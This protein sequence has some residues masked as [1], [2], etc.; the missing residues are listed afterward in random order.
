MRKAVIAAAA[1]LAAVVVFLLATLPSRPGPVSGAVGDRQAN[2]A[3]PGAYHVHSTVSDG[4][5][6]RDAIARSAARA[7][8]R[9]VIFTDHGDGTRVPQP[10]AYVHGVLCIDGVEIST[11]GGHYVALDMRPASYPLGGE[12]AAV[13]EDVRRLGGFGIAAHPSSARGEL[14][15]SDWDAPF[16]AV[17]WLNADSEWRDESALSLLRLPFDYLIRPAAALASMLDRPAAAIAR[18]DGL[19]S[20]RPVVGIAGHDAHGGIARPAEVGWRVGIPGIP[21]YEASFRAFSLRAILAAPLSGGP[22]ADARLVLDAI[23][24]G[25]VFTAI[26]AI[27]APAQLDFTATAGAIAAQMGDALPFDPAVELA[28]RSTLPEAGRLVLICDG[29][30]VAESRTGELR[31][32]PEGPMACRPEVRAPRA[33]GDPPVPWIVGNAIHLLAAVTEPVGAEP[34]F[35]TTLALD[36]LDWAVEKDP[37]SRASLTMEDGA[38]ILKYELRGGERVSQYVAAAAALAPPVPPYDRILFTAESSAP[39]RISVQLR[40]EGVERWVRSVY[41]EP[42]ARRAIVPLSALVSADGGAGAAAPDFRRAGS[43]LFVVDLTNA[44]PGAV[45]LVRISDLSFARALTR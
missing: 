1:I 3:V 19:S 10:P 33:P 29:R 34:L 43:I 44:P 4:A 13:I 37:A 14:G 40:F 45:G 25:R 15:W 9:F 36:H 35:E 31:T 41:V 5:A 26:D 38:L 7:G 12:A 42:D 8:L 22:A 24:R 11:N 39:M 18:W 21:S 27:A 30:E 32:R 2:P 20:R 6:D 16:D 23:R 28:A 17:E